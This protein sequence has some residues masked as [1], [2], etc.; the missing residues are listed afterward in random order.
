MTTAVV[1]AQVP[2]GFTYQAIAFNPSGNP[3]ANG[4]VSVKISILNNSVT[5]TNLYTETHSKTTN[6]KGLINLNIGQGTPVSGTFSGINWAINS[7]FIKVEIDPAGG[8]NYTSVGTNQLMSVPYA[9]TASKIDISSP[10][11]S[12][13]DDILESKSTSHFFTDK[14]DGKVYVL[15]SR[16][17][18][19]SPQTYNVGYTNN[20]TT[21]EVTANN[22]NVIFID[23]YDGKV[24]IFSSRAGTW[25]S[26][27]YNVGYTNNN[28]IPYLFALSNGST[29]FIDKFDHKIYVYN[30]TS[31]TWS[32]QDFNIGYTNNNIE[33]STFA[34]GSN[35]AFI[36]KYDHKVVVYN[37]KT[38]EWKS[39]PYS[40]TYYNNNLSSPDIT[41]SNGNFIFVDRYDH[42]IYVFNAK[43]GN[44]TSQEYNVGY[45]NNNSIPTLLGSETN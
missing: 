21:P 34:S 18:I 39:Q 1:F 31:G 35:F 28:I 8:T 33:P 4:N 25:S 9:M 17:G 7:K 6:S 20:N 43:T 13:G 24:Y 40:I 44:W 42:K 16:T 32:S 10:G 19:W 36:D 5:G 30:Y 12:I 22:G 29:L 37:T 38:M 11:S 41:R 15:S 45:L 2:Q 26:Q 14:Y 3:V 23:K 27:P